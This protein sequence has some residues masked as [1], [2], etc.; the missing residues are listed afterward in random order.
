MGEVSTERK[1]NSNVTTKIPN[2]ITELRIGGTFYGSIQKDVF[3]GDN[4]P[5][6][7]NFSLYRSGGPYFHPDSDD[8]QANSCTLPNVCSSVTDYNVN[9]NDFRRFDTTNTGDKSYN[10]KSL[11]NLLTLTLSNNYY[12]FFS[13]NN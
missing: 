4:F 7:I 13:S 3:D 9:S 1:L 11:T 10:V 5:N 6:L 2:T 12:V 8:T